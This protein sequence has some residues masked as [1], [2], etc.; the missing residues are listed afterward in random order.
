[1]KFDLHVHSNLSYDAKM[2]SD[3]I[4][5][6]AKNAG[7]S[8]VAICDHNA[9]HLH[10]QRENFYIIQSCEFSTD[11]GHLIVYFQKEHIN[12]ALSRDECGRFYWRDIC[13]AAHDQGAL[14]FLAH[15]Y[16]PLRPRSDVLFKEIDGIEIFNSR[17]V[18]SRRT[19]AN[20]NAIKLCKRL[21]KPF[22]A[23]SDA[24][25]PTEIGTTFWECDLPEEAMGDPDFEERLKAELLASRGRVFAGCASPFEVLRCKRYMYR[26]EGLYGRLLKS[27]LA[28]I[29]YFFKSLSGKKFKSHYI[30]MST[31]NTEEE[32]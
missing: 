28:L 14:V 32:S 27:Y 7:L 2:T 24:H 16:A 31:D 4:V 18:H 17:V 3:E 25:S 13:K 22:C 11:A 1:M 21:G 23:G 8:G 29:I 12:E 6:A 9:F 10:R 26:V 15:P 30:D 20:E 5:T 19:Y